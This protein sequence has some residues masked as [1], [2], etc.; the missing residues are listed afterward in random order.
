MRMPQRCNILGNTT[1]RL[2][3]AGELDLGA[4]QGRSSSRRNTIDSKLVEPA[5]GE[6]ARVQQRLDTANEEVVIYLNV[7]RQNKMRGNRRGFNEP[8]CA[9]KRGA[10]VG[11]GGRHHPLPPSASLGTVGEPQ[12]RR[13]RILC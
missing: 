7:L 11:V 10:G 13:G 4:D 12:G 2:S 5:R 3:Y 1:T 6:I 8:G 9:L